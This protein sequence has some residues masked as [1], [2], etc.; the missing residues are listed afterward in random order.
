MSKKR[1][2]GM[3]VF[4][5]GLMLVLGFIACDTGTDGT[6]GTDLP[7]STIEWE[8]DEDGFVRFYTNDRIHYWSNHWEFFDRSNATY[9][10][11]ECK[12]ISGHR[13]QGYGLIFGASDTDY[14]NFYCLLIDIDGYYYIGK[15][16]GNASEYEYAPIIGWTKSPR[17]RTGYNTLNT[18]KVLQSESTYT[19]FLNDFSHHTFD[20][21]SIIGS[22]LG[23]YVGVGDVGKESFPNKPVD[24]RFRQK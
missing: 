5:I 23:Y 9:Y 18:L 11:I 20:Y 10:E 7:I 2:G 21:E 6:P 24:V 16:I 3:P 12:K 4:I 8:T 13:D 22:R 1:L 19:I 14:F 15:R 17:L